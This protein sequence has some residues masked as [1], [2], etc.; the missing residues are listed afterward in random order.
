MAAVAAVLLG[1]PPEEVIE[2]VKEAVVRCV[3]E[4]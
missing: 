1:A 2:T 4:S 3:M